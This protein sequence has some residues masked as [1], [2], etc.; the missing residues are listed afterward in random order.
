MRRIILLTAVFA[1]TIG[2]KSEKEKEV[3]VEEE[4]VV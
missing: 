4:K 2:C 3:V 1:L